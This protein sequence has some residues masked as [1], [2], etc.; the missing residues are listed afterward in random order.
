VHAVKLADVTVAVVCGVVTLRHE[1]A[2][3]IVL[4]AAER[5]REVGGGRI[6]ANNMT[7][8]TDGHVAVVDA[9][10]IDD[11]G[12]T[13]ALRTLLD[14][15]LQTIGTSTAKLRLCACRPE[16]T[17]MALLVRELEG[18]VAPLD[19]DAMRTT[20]AT[21]A[22]ATWEAVA[23]GTFV[24]DDAPAVVDW[25]PKTTQTETKPTGASS[26]LDLAAVSLAVP[27]MRSP[28]PAAAPPSKRLE[29][30]VPVTQT[31]AEATRPKDAS[32]VRSLGLDDL[33]GVDD[34]AALRAEIA[35]LGTALA[36][37][38][39]DR[40]R[41]IAL[42]E[43]DRDRRVAA[44]EADRVRR[45]HEAEA[46]RDRRVRDAE[47]ERDR[48][49]RDL[50]QEITKKV[51]VI[52]AERDRRLLAKERA[53]EAAAA[54]HAE[55][56]DQLRA[57]RD[58]ERAESEALRGKQIEDAAARVRAAAESARDR[59]IDAMKA[60]HDAALLALRTEHEMERKTMKARIDE[61][62]YGLARANAERD[63]ERTLR[64]DGEVAAANRY[65]ELRRNIPGKAPPDEAR[66]LGYR[67]LDAPTSSDADRK[68]WK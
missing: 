64:V 2:G 50:E 56:M 60:A 17:G 40:D 8:D 63:A 27:V 33:D 23:D 43:K 31:L 28:A 62:E 15:L 3:Y 36:D 61:L 13:R 51:G 65:R 57:L 4:Q 18:A 49:V 42:L 47:H 12:S 26:T 14:G 44:V 20:V 10:K 66:V 16:D 35:R 53:M 6:D 30:D 22:R 41:R 9:P 59:A 39:A 29:V 45:V 1:V 25:S 68:W 34:P 5:L 7:I 55:E 11:V 67:D 24:P 54:R 38:A 58:Q 37:A 48:R 32:A 19:R 52:E 21:L 46:E